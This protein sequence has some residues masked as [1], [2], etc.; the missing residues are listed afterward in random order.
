MTHRPAAQFSRADPELFPVVHPV[1][2]GYRLSPSLLRG[3]GSKH[4]S[5]PGSCPAPSVLPGARIG[6]APRP[7]GVFWEAVCSSWAPESLKGDMLM[8]GKF[9]GAGGGRT[10]PSEP[11]QLRKPGTAAPPGAAR[12][13]RGG[14][15]KA[16]C[17][18]RGKNRGLGWEDALSP[19]ADMQLLAGLR[20]GN[21]DPRAD[22][23]SPWFPWEPTAGRKRDAAP[24]PF[25]FKKVPSSC[26]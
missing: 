17:L 20:V 22:P 7:H 2:P 3:P 5:P 16:A 21:G 24:F 15:C 18:E 19:A 25:L 9:Y 26:P 1:P 12:T 8:T 14:A 4:R 23:Q 13:G 11:H 10:R 6:T